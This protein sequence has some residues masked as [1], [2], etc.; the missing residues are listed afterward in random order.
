M[1]FSITFPKGLMTMNNKRLFIAHN[2]KLHRKASK[3]PKNQILD[4]LYMLTGISIR[5]VIIMRKIE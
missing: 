5:I 1:Y 3:K 4:E 2:V